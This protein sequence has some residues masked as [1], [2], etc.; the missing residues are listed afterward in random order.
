M[1]LFE[2]SD[3]FKIKFSCTLHDFNIFISHLTFAS[4]RPRAG[5]ALSRAEINVRGGATSRATSGAGFS[6][7]P[8]KSVFPYGQVRLIAPAGRLRRI[9]GV[10]T[11]SFVGPHEA[12]GLASIMTT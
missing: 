2:I 3:F 12:A 1:K 4:R 7:P 11:D 6:F 8:T 10:I 5:R 9:V